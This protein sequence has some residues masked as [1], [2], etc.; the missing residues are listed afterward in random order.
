MEII[1]HINDFLWTYLLIAI[2][3]GGGL[4]FTISTRAIQFRAIPEMI[5]LLCQSAPRDTARRHI[6][7]FQAFAISLASRVGTGNIAGVAIAIALGG[8]G[9][10]FWMWVVAIIGA[11]NA[12]VESTQ[13]E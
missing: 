7:S 6:T 3:L 12:F 9:A 2:L 10:V 5:R 1:N 8:P 13:N 11:A 4:Y